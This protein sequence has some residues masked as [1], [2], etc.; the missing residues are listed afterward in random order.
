MKKG[1]ALVEMV[2][3]LGLAAAILPALT[4]S[5]FA[6]RGGGVQE[7]IRMQANGRLREAREI[8]RLLKEDNWANI[9]TDGTYHLTLNNG[10]WNIEP[11]P[12]YNLDNLFT[13]QIILAPAYRTPTNQLSSSSSG[14]TLDPSVR[15]VTITVSWTNPIASSVIA[16]YYL[17]RLENLTW[18][19]TTLADFTLGI[20]LGTATTNTNGGEVI[21]GSGGASHADWCAPSLS[22]INYD[23]NGSANPNAISSAVGENGGPNQVIAGTG[24]SANGV[25]LDHLAVTNTNPPTVS[26]EG[27]LPDSS[28]RIK[29]NSVFVSG[30][31]AYIATDD[32]HKEVIIVDLN[33]YTESGYFNAPVNGNGAG[34]FVV[35]SLGFATVDNLLYTFDLTG[36]SGDRGAPLATLTLNGTGARLVVN[37]SY[38]YVAESSGNRA[39]EIIEFSTDGKTLNLR[40]WASLSGQN[41]VDIVVNST[42]SRGYLATSQGNVYILDTTSPYSGALPAPLGIFNTNGMTPKGIAVVTN[43][44]AI[45]VGT[46]G[47][48]QYQVIDITSENTPILCTNGGTTSGG[49]SIPSGVNGISAV[50]E[51]DG[52]TYSYI[53]TGDSA[54]EFKII[55]GGGGGGGG[56]YA[57]EGIFES[58]IFDA[59]HSVMFNRFTVTA[60]APPPDTQ[61]QYQVAISNPIGNCE[62][63]TYTFVGP[64]KTSGSYY[65]GSVSLPLGTG[66]GFTNPGQC[67]KYRAYLTTTNTNST[68]V[69]Y[70]ITFNYSP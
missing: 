47:V 2:L 49:L 42:A 27:T 45:V 20:Q 54:A 21:L 43:N 3:G 12:E 35:G 14:N 56:T 16:D 10:I 29:T 50:Q 51:E 19:Q 63:A 5:F 23:I 26:E 37:G 18:I 69:L 68:P 48:Q 53:I 17:M 22:A 58:S 33:T 11:N 38:V 4:T 7:Q 61:I 70:D 41:G 24:D 15:H 31:F 8:L 1:Q 36:K 59:G 6:A 46:G 32:N 67:L 30:S 44:R 34:L 65:A 40:G 39:M 66:A 28:P 57:N 60:I 52:D 13:R 9:E 55:Q 25:A 62:G 64:D